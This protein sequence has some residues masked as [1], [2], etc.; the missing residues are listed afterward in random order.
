MAQVV[1]RWVT[2]RT[3]GAI[4]DGAF[5]MLLATVYIAGAGP[6]GRLLGAPVWLMVSSGVALLIGGGIAIGYTR[7]RSMR[8]YTQLMVAYDGGWVLAALAGLLM[9]WQGSSAG[10]EV[11]IG[12][13]TAA[14]VAFAALLAA[15]TPA[16]TTSDIHA[17]VPAR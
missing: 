9:A 14:P 12:Y 15:A 3:V 13:Q 7:S 5:K 2:R 11:W 1:A 8:T 10:G 16:Q 17:E 6:L 4:A